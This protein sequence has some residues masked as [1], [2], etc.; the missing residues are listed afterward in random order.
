MDMPQICTD[1]NGATTWH[2]NPATG[3]F[4]RTNEA[5]ADL[6]RISGFDIPN[7]DILWKTRCDSRQIA[8]TSIEGLKLKPT[9]ATYALFNYWQGVK[10]A[11]SNT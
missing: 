1:N 5:G 7:P 6:G 4:F 8:T 11:Y 10:D 9:D 2:F 3:R